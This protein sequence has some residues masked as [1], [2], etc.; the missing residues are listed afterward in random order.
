MATAFGTY[1]INAKNQLVVNRNVVLDGTW[2][3]TK[4]HDLCLTFDGTQDTDF[5]DKVILEGT[6]K[7]VSANELSF[8]VTNRTDPDKIKTETVALS[9]VWKAD[10]NNKLIFKV[11]KESGR[12]DVLTFNNTWVIDEKNRI[13]YN[14]EKA[15]LVFKK[16]EKSQLV[17]KGTWDITKENRLY[18]ELSESS[19]S[20]FDFK[21]GTSIL[22]KNQ[23]KGKI[24]VGANE[25]DF[26]ITGLWKVSKELGLTFEVNYDDNQF[27]PIIFGGDIQLNDN[28]KL[29]IKFGNGVDVKLTQDILNGKADFFTAVH[30]GPDEDKAEWGFGIKF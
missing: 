8:E 20:G 18:Y 11:K 17:F 3:L 16:K 29:S 6:I 15:S 21:V 5:G 2:S 14:Y 4:D 25:N 19:D 1:S 30:S 10:E 26:A 13:I 24:M 7:D 22:E 28:D 27:K 12:H 23:I 9:G